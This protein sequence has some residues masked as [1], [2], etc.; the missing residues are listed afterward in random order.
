MPDI[1]EDWEYGVAWTEKLETGNEEIDNQHRHIFKLTSNIIESCQR[2]DHKVSVEETLL[3]LADYVVLH[4]KDE[5]KLSLESDYPQYEEHKKMHDDFKETVG[6][7]IEQYK[8]E[9]DNE[10]LMAIVNKEI[11]KWLITHI[12]LEDAKIAKHIKETGNK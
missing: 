6:G 1:I 9:S 3:F 10:A 12:R 8:E 2:K 7:F 11:G 4:F 5:E